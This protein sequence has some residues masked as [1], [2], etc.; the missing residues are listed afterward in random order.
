MA[1]FWGNAAGDRF[2]GGLSGFQESKTRTI[3]P[4]AG[5]SVKYNP[6]RWSFSLGASTGGRIARYSLNPQANLNTMDT[7]FTASGSYT[8]RHEFE[9]VSDLN[10]VFYRGYAAGYGQPEWQ[11]NA[12]ISKNIGAFNLSVKVYDILD[13]TRNLT[14]TVTANYEEDTYRL[15]MGRH[16]LFGVKWNFGKMNAAHSQRARDAAWNLVF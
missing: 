3:S 11:W 14:H 9:F 8:T 4:S 6:E 1:E 12:E 2:Y 10:Y 5:I 7:R 15:V 16:I 13:Q